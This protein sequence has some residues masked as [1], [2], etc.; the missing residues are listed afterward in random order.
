MFV[1]FE[2]RCEVYVCIQLFVI[3]K[4]LNFPK[5]ILNF[6]K[7]DILLNLHSKLLMNLCI[8]YFV[9]LCFQFHL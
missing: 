9:K 6:T 1:V 2:M 4:V 5:V 8:P 3:K 7:I